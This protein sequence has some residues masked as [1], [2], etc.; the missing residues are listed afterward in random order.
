MVGIVNLLPVLHCSMTGRVRQRPME[1]WGRGAAAGD[2]SGR[3]QTAAADMRQ[4]GGERWRPGGGGRW[5]QAH[6]RP[7]TWI[8]SI[9]VAALPRAGSGR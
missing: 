8:V 5:G 7:P 6:E 3:R 2:R 1:H 9:G 4:V